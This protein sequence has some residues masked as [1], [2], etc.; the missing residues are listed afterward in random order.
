VAGGSSLT[1]IRTSVFDAPRLHQNAILATWSGRAR[2]CDLNARMNSAGEE[3]GI[4]KNGDVFTVMSIL[5]V[6]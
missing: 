4:L 3:I 2:E 6:P 1:G 5:S